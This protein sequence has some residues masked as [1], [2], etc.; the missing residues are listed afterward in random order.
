MSTPV[1]SYW[2][3]I[4]PS[5]KTT[6]PVR[7]LASDEARKRATWRIQDTAPVTMHALPLPRSIFD[8]REF[9]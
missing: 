3:V 5:A 9:R 1:L 6:E 8:A 2:A 4:P 7:K